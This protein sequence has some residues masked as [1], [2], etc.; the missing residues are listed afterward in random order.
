MKENGNT[1]K[2]S[3]SK[4]K[5]SKRTEIIN[6]SI[7]QESEI[8]AKAILEKL[9]SLVI[10]KIFDN[11]IESKITTFC[12]S[13]MKN[14]IDN[15]IDI[16]FINHDKDDL[17]KKKII[18]T[19]SQ[20]II[21]RKDNQ[22]NNSSLLTEEKEINKKLKSLNK[23]QILP[24]YELIKALN[25]YNSGNFENKIIL[26]I[27][28]RKNWN[29]Q[30]NKKLNFLNPD[31]M[32]NNII[33]EE[34]NK[35]YNFWDTILQ[36]KNTKID[37]G[38]ST[39]IKIDNESFKNKILEDIQENIIEENEPHKKNEVKQNVSNNAHLLIKQHVKMILKKEI[40]KKGKKPRVLIPTDLPSFDLEPEKNGINDETDSIKVL[41]KEYEIRLAIKKEKEEKE[42]KFMLQ[43]KLAENLVDNVDK[44]IILKKN[45]N[46]NIV[47]INPIKIDDLI[48]EFE[49]LK[50]KTKEVG[51]ITDV[52][53]DSQSQ[54]KHD[55]KIE[56]NDNPNYHFN[57]E[58]VIKKE[59]NILI[60]KLIITQIILQIF[61]K[62]SKKLKVRLVLW[63]KAAQNMPQVPI[64]I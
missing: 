1:L 37:R 45:P 25:P 27:L 43:K 6:V 38:A 5:S 12:L 64:I 35:L 40:E 8:I 53:A 11:M 63:K 46:A 4:L 16:Q 26:N 34:K 13:E 58:R 21:L 14:K 41:R 31:K 24:E 57:E 28:S 30:K 36:P 54:K 3:T 22:N 32:N 23:S 59:K 61:L 19:K 60:N 39:K 49:I 20:K 50:S 55:I 9:I 56:I 2:K 15:I 10:S 33:I 18:N 7:F 52:N 44:K 51:K 42:K 17:N 47:K 29:I 48:N 62:I